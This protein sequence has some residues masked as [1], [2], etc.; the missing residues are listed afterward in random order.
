MKRAWDQAVL[1]VL[2]WHGPD[3]AVGDVLETSTGRRYLIQRFRLSRPVKGKTKIR[4]FEIVVLPKDLPLIKGTKVHR[5]VW[6]KRTPRELGRRVFEGMQG[7]VHNKER[8]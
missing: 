3:P 5:W 2:W 7:H 4:A 6:G 8:Q 1:T